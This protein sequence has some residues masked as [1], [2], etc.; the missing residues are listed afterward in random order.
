MN[1]EQ[2]FF[3]RHP[4]GGAAVFF[5]IIVAVGLVLVFTVGERPHYR[6]S[7]WQLVTQRPAQGSMPV[8]SEWANDPV[9]V[10]ILVRVQSAA[11]APIVGVEAAL[12]HLGDTQRISGG[13]SGEPGGH[14]QLPVPG[15]V[16]EDLF[17]TRLGVVL[18]LPGGALEQAIIPPDKGEW[19]AHFSLEGRSSIVFRVLEMDGSPCA[20]DAFAFPHAVVGRPDPR[21]VGL[22]VTQGA[23][24]IGGCEQGKPFGITV[25]A[26]DGRSATHTVNPQDASTHEVRLPPANSCAS[27]TAVDIEGRPVQMA[28][29]GAAPLDGSPQ[30]SQQQMRSADGRFA[31][32]APACRYRVEIVSE[33]GSARSAALSGPQ[34]NLQLR[35]LPT[36]TISGRVA[37]MKQGTIVA[38][39]DPEMQPAKASIQSQVFSDG[40]FS[41][42]GIPSGT[43]DLEVRRPNFAHIRVTNL[44][45][46]PGGLCSD[47]R[48]QS[49]R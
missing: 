33:G 27:G 24:S 14:V 10:Q 37:E 1:A 45:V 35:L 39:F 44:Q 2:G 41:I 12:A 30:T 28:F 31:V 8:G 34:Q 19:I 42:S 9:R 15:R 11:G 16:D 25:I 32:V 26:A 5:G 21:A 18:L 4:W 7:T 20:A 43:W 23:V 17:A 36:G 6:N 48:L 47:P 13:V 38:L 29:V 49:V 3:S 22:Q 46:P 40:Q